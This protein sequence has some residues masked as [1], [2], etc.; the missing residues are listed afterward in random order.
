MTATC[1]IHD[2]QMEEKT[3][4]TKFNQDGTAKTYFAH[5]TNGNLCFGESIKKSQN[6]DRPY[7]QPATVKKHDSMLMCNAMNNACLLVANG[8]IVLESR[9]QAF[10]DI[11]ADLES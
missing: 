5:V 10:N 4:K 2:I 9:T 3:S 1:T 6:N 7:T 11:L 8:I